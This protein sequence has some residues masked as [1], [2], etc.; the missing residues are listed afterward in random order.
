MGISG[1]EAVRLEEFSRLE[2]AR[3]QKGFRGL[4]RAKI[5]TYT[6]TN[7]RPSPPAVLWPLWAPPHADSAWDYVC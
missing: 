4:R 6:H 5:Y 1:P 3:F 2:S 7:L